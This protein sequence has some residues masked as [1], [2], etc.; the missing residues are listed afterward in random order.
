MGI[1]NKNLSD[2]DINNNNNKSN[3]TSEWLVF[4]YVV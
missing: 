3:K 4:F 1:L 2:N